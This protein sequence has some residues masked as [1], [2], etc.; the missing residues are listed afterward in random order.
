MKLKFSL[1]ILSILLGTHLGFPQSPQITYSEITHNFGTIGNTDGRVSH[2]F[3]IKNNSKDQP[4]VISK[5]IASCGCTTPNWTQQPIEPGK[6]GKI[7]VA[8]NPAGAQG[9]ITKTIRVMTNL[10]PTNTVLYIKANVV[11]G[12][13]D[14]AESYPVKIGNLLFKTAPELDFGTID[15]KE[16]KT[17]NIEAYNNSD[18]MQPIQFNLPPYISAE[19]DILPAKVDVIFNFTFDPEK[20]NQI[21]MY[22]GKLTLRGEKELIPYK[23]FIKENFDHLTPEEIK[24][25]GKINLNTTQLLFSKKS[26][27]NAEV[28]K[29]ANSGKKD[30][31]I[32]NIQSLNKNITFS[33]TALIVKPNEITEV[34]INYP[35]QKIKNPQES[36]VVYILSDDPKNPVKEIKITVNP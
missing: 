13:F 36:S 15:A 3:T 5:V 24:E 35:V 1:L 28:L 4:L 22:E 23:A 16:K 25:M 30:L 9:S 8:Y 26:K 7:E 6:T 14:P 12:K 33:K 10:E 19:P 32:K 29:I 20:F 34:K 31:H 27:N 17:I 18:E 21:G 2:E 11:E